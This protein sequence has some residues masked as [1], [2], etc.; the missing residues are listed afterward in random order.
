MF[1]LKC[2]KAIRDQISIYGYKRAEN[3]EMKEGID[4]KSCMRGKCKCV[5]VT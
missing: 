1:S 5:A 2:I 3:V 4:E